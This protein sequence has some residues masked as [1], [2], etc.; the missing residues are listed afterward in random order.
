MLK[1]YNYYKD[2]VKNKKEESFDEYTVL[3]DFIEDIPTT[4]QE[5]EIIEILKS[6]NGVLRLQKALGV[7]EEE[8]NVL[9]NKF[10]HKS[11]YDANCLFRYDNKRRIKLYLDLYLDKVTIR[12]MTAF[13]I[14]NNKYY[15]IKNNEVVSDNIVKE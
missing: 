3:S 6:N 11:R 9:V 7:K 10:N 2:I 15:E 1:D 4:L 5:D 12:E 8:P 13:D 14:E